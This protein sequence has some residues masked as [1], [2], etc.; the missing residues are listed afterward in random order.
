MF[1]RMRAGARPGRR[2][3]SAGPAGRS[4]R[5]ELAVARRCIGLLYL[6]ATLVAVVARPAML[7]AGEAGGFIVLAG[8]PFLLA[9]GWV[10]HPWGLQRAI[11]REAG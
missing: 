5:R 9:L 1:P 6:A 11:G 7:A 2:P 4:R 3:A 10:I 8:A